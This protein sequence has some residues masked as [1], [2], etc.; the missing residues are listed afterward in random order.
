MALLG[1]GTPLPTATAPYLV[2]GGP[3]R[4][5]RNP[6]ALAGIVQ[7]V[8]VG[9]YFGSLAVIAYAFTGALLWH[10][11]VRPIEEADLQQRFPAD[12]PQ[13]REAVGLW[14]PRLPAKRNS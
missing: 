5:V 1:N 8:A 12:Y 3:Y 6:M 10:F 9:W 7:G 4:F 14:L 11:C 13:Y 2:V